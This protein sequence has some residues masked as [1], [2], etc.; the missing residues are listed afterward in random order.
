MIEAHAN[1]PH[2]EVSA[3]VE[4]ARRHDGV[5]PLSEQSLLFLR[6]GGDGLGL[7][8]RTAGGALAGYAHLGGGAGEL[9]VHPEHRRQGHGTALLRALL[10]RE[11]GVQVW[12]H[13]DLPGA[14]ALA[15]RLGL[16]RSRVLLQLRRPAADPLPPFELAP[17]VAV[18]AFEPGRDEERWL[19]VNR[20]AFADHPEQGAWT[21]DDVRNREAEPWF[22]PAGFFLAE[23]DGRLL[24]FHW[25]KVHPGGV[26]EVYVVGVDPAAQGLGL[27]RALTL[28]GLH[29]LRAAGQRQVMLYVDESNRAA[30]NLYE[31]LGFARHAV[32]TM[33]RHLGC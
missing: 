13:G 16:E 25:T 4:A 26:G 22:D 33:Y 31:S 27:G 18:R 24:G 10:D 23:R 19:E 14:T 21:L 5:A 20:R 15:E 7:T 30:V 29:H 2:D 1:P 8:L 12:A 17:G 9:V 32:D 3:L 28:I 11:P 6:H